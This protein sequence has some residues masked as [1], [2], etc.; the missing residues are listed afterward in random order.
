MDEKDKKI[1]ALE[2]DV[3]SLK[4]ALKSAV[5]AITTL[6]KKVNRVYHAHNNTAST[7]SSIAA[8]LRRIGG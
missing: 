8:Q 1:A 5:S 6:E 4:K 2:K 3:D 7:V